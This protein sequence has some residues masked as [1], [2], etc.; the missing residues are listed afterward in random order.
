MD[1]LRP[2]RKVKRD[3]VLVRQVV[4]EGRGQLGM[5]TQV[6][7]RRQANPLT[8]FKK[9]SLFLFFVGVFV[10]SLCCS[11]LILLIVQ[12]VILMFMAFMVRL[13]SR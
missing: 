12:C 2:G 9:K 10:L 1:N 6:T 3:G 13:L 5:L 11:S 8:L 7:K 4:V